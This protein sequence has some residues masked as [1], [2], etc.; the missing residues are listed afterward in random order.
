MLKFC[1]V[2]LK[3]TI[4]SWKKRKNEKSCVDVSN[5]EGLGVFVVG[6]NCLYD[7]IVLVQRLLNYQSSLLSNAS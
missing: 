2:V 1:L 7:I 3:L 5:E 6:K 4:Y